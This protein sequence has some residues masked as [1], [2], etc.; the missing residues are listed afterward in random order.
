MFSLKK[1]KKLEILSLLYYTVYMPFNQTLKISKKPLFW[2]SVLLFVFLA[3]GAIFSL[4]LP[5]FQG[6]DEQLHYATIQYRAE[7]TEKNWPL[8]HMVRTIDGGD[9]STYHFSE[10]T[11]KSAQATQF[12]EVKFQNENTQTFT[13]SSTGINEPMIAESSWKR[14]I[15]TYQSD[16][17]GTSSFYYSFGT[18]MEKLFSHQSILFR[19][20]SI[21]LFSVI[22]GTLVILLAYLT[23][24]KIGF[25]AW[26]SLIVASLVAFQPML[27]TTA[28]QVNIDIA[29]IFSFS[30]FIYAAVSLL[31]DGWRWSWIALLIFSAGLGLY[32]KG[33]GLIL[34]VCALPL[35]IFV[36]YRHFTQISK[37][38]FFL[39]LFLAGSFIFGLTF[40]FVPASYLASITNITATS[41]FSSPSESISRYF[42]KTI[43]QGALR[44]TEASYWGHFGWL[45]T[46]VSGRTIDI[47][48][49]LEIIAWIGAILFLISK[50]QIGYLPEK[51]YIVFSVGIIIAL[52]LAIRF[53]DWRVFDVT[54]QIL[55]GTPGRYFLP[56]IIPHII[57]M[58]T[59]LGYFTRNKKQFDT[60][61]KVLLILMILFSLY[62]MFDI[63]IP[64]YYL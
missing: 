27:A 15:D 6:P 30:L 20:F 44:D 54:K 1:A 40:T 48:W 60:L 29:L 17:S 47:I 37:R 5:F 61:L 12:D 26:H 2:L 3:K 41:H 51:K 49:T 58:V 25:S 9:I 32:S 59:G 56:N 42:D 45:D 22:L 7:P 63:I 36:A 8:R 13:Q 21:R 52:E 46:K 43:R 38:N 24:R 55:I 64:R 19:F 35:L 18:Q 10:E 11:I 53:Y 33:P 31:R 57:L 23:T 28:A 16:V 14:Y 39:G 34:I 4:S 62:A 50:K